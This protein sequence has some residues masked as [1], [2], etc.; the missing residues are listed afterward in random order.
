MTLCTGEVHLKYWFS[1][2]DTTTDSD[3]IMDPFEARL[4]LL[5]LVGR[6]NASASSEVSV[7]NFMIKNYDLRDDLYA[8]LLEELENTAKDN[9][10]MRNNVMWTLGTLCMR[11]SDIEHSNRRFKTNNSTDNPE[12]RNMGFYIENIIN[13]LVKVTTQLVCTDDEAGRINQLT[14]IRFLERFR[15][16]KYGESV[17]K[18]DEADAEVAK[19]L[20]I[21]LSRKKPEEEETSIKLPMTRQQMFRR[22]D[23]DRERSKLDRETSWFIPRGEDEFERMWDALPGGFLTIDKDETSEEN[24]MCQLARFGLDMTA[25]VDHLSATKRRRVVN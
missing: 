17:C 15:E 1:I 23:E 4:Q 6:L 12:Y 13:D 8:C 10:N 24:E 3:I 9:V 19:A 22:M 20:D 2:Q 11:I 16:K 18:G 25:A 14:T 7:A 5:K 21:I